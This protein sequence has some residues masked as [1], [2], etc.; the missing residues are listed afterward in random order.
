MRVE[1][2][3]YQ[4]VH[5]QEEDCL[6]IVERTVRLGQPVDRLFYRHGDEVCPKPE[7]IPFL[8]RQTRIVLETRN[9][10]MNI[11]Q[12]EALLLLQKQLQR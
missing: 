8:N 12:Q 3:G 11:L 7:D 9:P 5:V 6:E 2:Y 10:L 4:Y 1:P